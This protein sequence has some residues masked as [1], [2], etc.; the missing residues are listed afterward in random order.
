MKLILGMGL[1]GLS[2]A[3]FFSSNNIAYRIADSRLS[4]PMHGKCKK[5][6]LLS[7]CHLGDWQE[8]LLDTVTEIIISP[9]IAETEAIVG[10][11]RLQK[12]PVISDIE[13][14]GRYAKAPIIGITGSNGKSTVTQLLGE[15]A[16]GSGKNAVIC[17]NIGKPVMESLSDEAEL[18]VVEM[19]SYQLDY[20]NNLNLL[21]GV[22]TNITP[23]HLDRY[24]N[25]DVYIASKLNLYQY[26]QYSVVNLDESLVQGIKGDSCYAIEGVTQSCDFS[27]K[28][29]DGL[30]SIYQSKD[31][32]M[33]SDELM[34]LGRHN[35]ENVL[36]ALTLGRQAG[37]SAQEMIQ[38]AKSFTGLPHRLEWVINLNGVDYYNDSKST[39][40]ISTITAIEA[41]SDRYKS[42]V[43]IAGGIA[44]KEDYSKLFQ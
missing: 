6:N 15:M 42:I 18:Y 14:F 1:T 35:V 33:T 31:I 43:L 34:V 27:A 12:I 37:L 16:I 4:P 29:V 41:L 30:Y 5:E 40:A 2:V 25:Y 13:L 20:T 17:G 22:V 19:S 7:D 39:S 36:A 3:R 44:K 32:L 26:C 21:T 28:K 10:W 38:V 24:P 11:A 8:S 23:D 9:G